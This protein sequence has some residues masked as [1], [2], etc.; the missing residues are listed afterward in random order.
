[1][2]HHKGKSGQQLKAGPDAEPKEKLTHTD[3]PTGQSDGGGGMF[4][5]KVPSSQVILPGGKLT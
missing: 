2:V 4:L 5:I 3:S 1:M